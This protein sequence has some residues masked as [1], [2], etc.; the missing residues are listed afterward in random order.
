[1]A[2]KLNVKEAYTEFL[3]LKNASAKR[4]QMYYFNR[5]AVKGNF[6]WPYDW[7]HHIPRITDNLCKPIVERFTTYLM[8]KGFTWN[9][10][11]PNSLEFRDAAERGEKIL[12]RVMALSDSDLQFQ[13]GAKMG[14]EM[15]RTIYKVYHR[16]KEGYRHACFETVQPDY[17]YP[18]FTGGGH[19][20]GRLAG[21][22]Y[23]YPLDRAEALDR[24]EE[25]TA[26][27]E[28]LEAYDT[29]RF[30]EAKAEFS[31]L[32]ARTGRHL[33]AL[34]AMRCDE[35]R[36]TPPEDWNGVWTFTAK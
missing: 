20:A 25:L 10:E 30:E 34:Y 6:R 16:G 8:G 32:E 24:I 4:N 31:A 11:R 28:A 13:E 1:M 7:P 15:G 23:S 26:Y 5:M 9:L 17:F 27:A 18:I 12:R 2:E 19:V 3:H 29:G 21:A 33:Y 14:S 35:L 36:A 22:Y